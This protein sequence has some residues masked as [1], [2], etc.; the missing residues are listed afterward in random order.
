M[1]D[2]QNPIFTSNVAFSDFATIKS[3]S[4]TNNQHYVDYDGNT[5]SY[6]IALCEDNTILSY[7]TSPLL[8]DASYSPDSIEALIADDSV[9]DFSFSFKSM[10]ILKAAS[11]H[12]I[13]IFD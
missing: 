9:L 5:M 12:S 3:F 7:I 1:T 8:S 11:I 10:I 6:T 4:S 2:I 13:K